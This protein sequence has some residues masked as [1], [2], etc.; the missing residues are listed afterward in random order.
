MTR[1]MET[2]IRV[3]ERR[4][5]GT[6]SACSYGIKMYYSLTS[7]LLGFWILLSAF[8]EITED[9]SF[10]WAGAIILTSIEIS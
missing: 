1:W 7:T 9:L 2:V 5:K 10:K 8:L 6:Y 4:T 3:N